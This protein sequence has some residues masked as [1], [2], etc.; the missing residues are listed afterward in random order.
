[1]SE[2]KESYNEEMIQ[3]MIE[4]NEQSIQSQQIE[5][6]NVRIIAK[7]KRRGLFYKLIGGLLFIGVS[8]IGL[9]YHSNNQLNEYRS[10]IVNQGTQQSKRNLFME[11]QAKREFIKKMQE[12]FRSQNELEIM[13]EAVE[14]KIIWRIGELEVPV[15]MTAEQE[16]IEQIMAEVLRLWRQEIG[17][18]T[19]RIVDDVIVKQGKSQMDGD[20]MTLARM[21]FGKLY[22]QIQ[23][24][25]TTDGTEFTVAV[26]Y[27]KKQELQDAKVKVTIFDAKG[28]EKEK[29]S[30]NM[31]DTEEFS[32]YLQNNTN[33]YETRVIITKE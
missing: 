32:I 18:G 23:K 17:T 9:F 6:E 11:E 28:E 20:Q 2:P 8:G 4:A 29:Q 7:K 14:E 1:M 5:D 27:S 12:V 3:I 25:A 24:F 10:V 16:S 22:D 33:H 26:T 19:L 13:R 30:I 31:K 21:K 15:P